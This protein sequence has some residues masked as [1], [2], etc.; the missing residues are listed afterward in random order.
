[1]R[2]RVLDK[3]N[4]NKCGVVNLYISKNRG[5]YWVCCYKIKNKYYYFDSFELDP[6][7]ELINY[8]IIDF[9]N[10]KI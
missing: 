9:S 7:L 6:L 10:L 2:N 5:I 3:I 8:K 4:D 1:M